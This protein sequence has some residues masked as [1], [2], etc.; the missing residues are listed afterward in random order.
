MARPVPEEVEF[1]PEAPAE[2]LAAMDGVA[3]GGR[4]WV[5]L[6]P[7]IDPEDLPPPPGPFAI[8]GG[9]RHQVPTATYLPRPPGRDG[10]TGQVDLGLQHGA[11]P[12]A[13]A[14][15]AGLGR[16][17]PDGWRIRQDHPRRGLVIEAPAGTGTPFI[18]DWL[19]GAATALCSVPM[20]GRWVATVFHEAT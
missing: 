20:T 18:L 10:R 14:R 15:L 3:G 1:R 6:R 7:V 8:F 19:V 5:N 12:R 4:G 17:V 2:A 11:G 13:A 9:S 16:P